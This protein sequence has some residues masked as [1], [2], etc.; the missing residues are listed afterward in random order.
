MEKQ[1]NK[2]KHGQMFQWP[3]VLK[4]RKET[5]QESLSLCSNSVTQKTFIEVDGGRF[6]ASRQKFF[7]QKNFFES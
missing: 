4:I 6:V 5:Y 2:L 3:W 7:L 1:V